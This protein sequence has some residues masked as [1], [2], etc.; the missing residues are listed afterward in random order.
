MA[1]PKPSNESAH[2]DFFDVAAF[3]IAYL[4]RKRR[5][6]E[7]QKV[8]KGDDSLIDVSKDD[9]DTIDLK[10]AAN[11]GSLAALINLAWRYEKGEGVEKSLTGAFEYY[12]QAADQGSAM[13]QFMVA[14]CFEKGRGTKRSYKKSFKYYKLAADQGDADAQT[15]VACFYEDGLGVKK[16]ISQAFYYYH[17]GAKKG[18]GIAFL[19]L[20]K[21]YEEGLGTSR[22]VTQALYYYGLARQKDV[23]IAWVLYA[24]LLL[25]SK[26]QK[27]L[28]EGIDVLK[29]ISKQS[30]TFADEAIWSQFL[31]GQCYENGTGVAPSFSNAIYYYRLAAAHGDRSAQMKLGDAYL[32]GKL[33]LKQ[34]Y[35][36]AFK[37]FKHVSKKSKD[38]L[39]GI[40]AAERLGELYHYGLGV[41]ESPEKSFY[42]FMRSFAMDYKKYKVINCPI[43][44]HLSNCLKYGI[45]TAASIPKYLYI[46][47]LSIKSHFLEILKRSSPLV[48]RLTTSKVRIYNFKGRLQT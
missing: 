18:N 31:L 48:K 32:Y 22:S 40:L 2:W 8:K 24:K 14:N 27:K 1:S 16:S 29:F 28:E 36:T 3:P 46:K 30:K 25:R 45:G 12:K 37:Y 7:C 33:G 44:M 23:P 42:Y 13:A 41:E 11:K 5:V 4:K 26:R 17:L 43:G 9:A 34:C 35:V 21:F 20:G 38:S 19:S 6:E 15:R 39:D 47:Y 10:I